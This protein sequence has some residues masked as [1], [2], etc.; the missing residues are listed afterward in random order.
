MPGDNQ[1][2]DMSR[3]VIWL[4]L[5]WCLNAAA[6]DEYFCRCEIPEVNEVGQPFLAEHIDRWEIRA[7]ALGQE[8]IHTVNGFT[9]T[10]KILDIPE[11]EGVDV[12]LDYRA[13]STASGFSSWLDERQC[14]VRGDETVCSPELPSCD[15]LTPSRTPG[16]KHFPLREFVQNADPAPIALGSQ[17]YQI[18]YLCNLPDTTTSWAPYDRANIAGHELQYRTY[19][20]NDEWQ[21]LVY[22]GNESCEGIF[23]HSVDFPVQEVRY[24]V[25][26]HEANHTEFT[27]PTRNNAQGSGL[28]A[29]GGA[30]FEHGSAIP[31]ADVKVEVTRVAISTAAAGNTQDI[32]IS[33]FGTPKAAIFI[34]SG[35]TTDDTIAAGLNFVL[36]FSEA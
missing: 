23:T 21:S 5:A 34:A 25:F 36:A 29:L 12:A 22:L 1:Y 24:A 32:T 27:D 14:E 31:V 13:H 30:K 7:R 2:F 6:L 35:A 11:V 18:K 19:G 9:C 4:A 15:F 28:V 26:D 10:T 33:G 8:R 16:V 17:Q 20:S 3:G